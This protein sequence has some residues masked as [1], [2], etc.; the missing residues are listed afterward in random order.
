MFFF[1]FCFISCSVLG[2]VVFLLTCF[3]QHYWKI[4]YQHKEHAQKCHFLGA[5]IRA[6][7]KFFFFF[8]LKLLILKIIYSQPTENG[9]LTCSP[10]CTLL[11]GG[12]F[13]SK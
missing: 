5:L 1:V 12:P 3:G 11:R 9:V 13:F 2:V 7:G 8:L 10:T 4:P 6:V